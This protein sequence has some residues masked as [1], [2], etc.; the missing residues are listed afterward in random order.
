MK[1]HDQ[2]EITGRT[3]PGMFNKR[4]G[5]KHAQPTAQGT[6]GLNEIEK[7]TMLIRYE[8][9]LSLARAELPPFTLEE[10]SLIANN[11]QTSHEDP[12][13]PAHTARNALF[14]IAD[15]IQSNNSAE[16]FGCDGERLL[17][18]LATLSRF[19]RIALLEMCERFWRDHGQA[20][21]DT[22]EGLRA[23]GLIPPAA[24]QSDTNV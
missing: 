4:G 22:A 15:D 13:F 12:S 14:D 24:T 8:Y 6:N 1:T 18:K 7:R 23:V 21:S 9:L 2:N 3:R 5:S 16:H 19:A 10:A 17:R 20:T 11:V